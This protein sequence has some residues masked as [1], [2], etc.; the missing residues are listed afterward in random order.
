MIDDGRARE[1]EMLTQPQPTSP[2]A[3]F[4]SLKPFFQGFGILLRSCS[5]LIYVTGFRVLVYDSYQYVLAYLTSR[6]EIC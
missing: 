3:L 1:R 6:A 2:K 4:S 5:L